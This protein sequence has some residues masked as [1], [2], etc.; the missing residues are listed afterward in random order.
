MIL[1][2]NSGDNGTIQVWQTENGDPVTTLR[3]DHSYERLDITGIK[4]LTDGQKRALK[5][6]GAVEHFSDPFSRLAQHPVA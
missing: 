2:W 6:M 5:L 1:V 3:C 4:G